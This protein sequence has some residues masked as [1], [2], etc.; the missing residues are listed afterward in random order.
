[1]RSSFAGRAHR[2]MLRDSMRRPRGKAVSLETVSDAG[3]RAPPRPLGAVVR[4]IDAKA[5][6]KTYRLQEGTC[7]LGAGA[8]ADIVIEHRSVSRAHVE[9]GLV[10]E[11]ISVR[12]LGSRNGTFYLGHRVQGI[13]L[14]PGARIH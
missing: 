11:G 1:M 14:A 4:V 10:P 5:T 9:L 7:I 13:M 3:R 2:I 8:D 12:D 6:P